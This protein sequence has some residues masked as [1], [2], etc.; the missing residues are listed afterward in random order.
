MPS[1]E[2]YSKNPITEALIDIQVDPVL[3]G[4]PQSLETIHQ[5]ISAEFPEK[6]TRQT[7]ASMWDASNKN[8][9]THQIS[10]NGYQFWSADKTEVFQA[11]IDGFSCSRLSPYIKWETHFPKMLANWQLYRDQFKPIN[12]KR[13]AVR[14]INVFKIPGTTFELK[15]YFNSP[16]EPPA[17]LPQA[18]ENFLS[19]LV[20][21]KNENCKAVIT[22]TIR[23]PTSPEFTPILL[24]ID[25]SKDVT[26]PADY[27][28]LTGEFE[29]LH[30]FA[31]EIFEAYI[32]N[33]TRELIR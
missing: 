7:I 29:S 33:R 28:G 14:Y 16:P 13:L 3:A 11:R 21:R 20:I 22:F 17:T 31:E 2:S 6:K 18:L 9:P 12:I 8:P 4:S 23:R 24:D 15:D 19:Q 27:Q 26:I 32:T 1:T 30:T 5:K 25:V 10:I